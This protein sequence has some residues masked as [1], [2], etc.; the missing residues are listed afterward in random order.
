MGGEV[1]RPGRVDPPGEMTALEAIMNADGFKKETAEVRN[2]V[3]GRNINGRT[4]DIRGSIS[5]K[6]WRVGKLSRSIFSPVISH[7]SR[8]R[9]SS[10]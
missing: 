1:K 10:T 4:V 8:K 7:M 9:L 5:G 3:I 6:P 2:A